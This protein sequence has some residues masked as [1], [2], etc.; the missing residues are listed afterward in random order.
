MLIPFSK[1]LM[2]NIPSLITDTNDFLRKLND[3]SHLI[4][5]ESTMI[6]MDVNTL[7]TN[8]PHTFGINACHSFLNRHTTDP[9]LKMTFQF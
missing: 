1:P 5:P 3:I 9:A 7:Y 8:I 4:T 2:H 6:T